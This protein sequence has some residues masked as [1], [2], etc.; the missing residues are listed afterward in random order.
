MDEKLYKQLVAVIRKNSFQIKVEDAD[1]YH[2]FTSASSR[3]GETVL[4]RCLTLQASYTY[5]NYPNGHRWFIPLCELH[6]AIRSLS[7]SD[8]EF[9]W[10]S[11]RHELNRYDAKRVIFYASHGVIRLNMY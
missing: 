7:E 10:R 8:R 3:E 4:L 9:M 5:G 2:E 6:G 1:G 11:R